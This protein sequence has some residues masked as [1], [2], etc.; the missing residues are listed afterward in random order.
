MVGQ[1]GRSEVPIDHPCHCV[2]LPMSWLNPL[3][4][5]SPTPN[6]MCS[7]CFPSVRFRLDDAT[8]P[9]LR[10]ADR[11]R[12]RHPSRS[13]RK[14]GSIPFRLPPWDLFKSYIH[15]RD[16]VRSLFLSLR[17]LGADEGGDQLLV[18]RPRVLGA[19]IVHD[20]GE[21][22]EYQHRPPGSAVEGDWPAQVLRG[23]QVGGGLPVRRG[24][25]DELPRRRSHPRSYV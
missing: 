13:P 7:T 11:R 17:V 3:H 18:F 6:P 9:D 20:G 23:G 4:T 12:D 2:L 1:P 16:P 8:V 10:I 19:H 14:A 22:H 21:L 25:P 15:P 5:T 24:D